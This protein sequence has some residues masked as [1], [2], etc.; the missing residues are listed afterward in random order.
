MW[1]TRCLWSQNESV[2]WRSFDMLIFKGSKTGS[3]ML[4]RNSIVLFGFYARN[5]F[6][7]SKFTTNF[8]AFIYIVEGERSMIENDAERPTILQ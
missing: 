5:K 2:V 8:C 6:S 1:A 7:L 3:V 4:R